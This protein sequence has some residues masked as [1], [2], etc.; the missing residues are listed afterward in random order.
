MEG[1]QIQNFG[2]IKEL[3]IELNS[4]NV[5]IGKQAS[6]KSITVKLIYFFKGIFREIIDGYQS[7]KSKAEIDS[8]IIKKF[9]E[10]FPIDNWPSKTFYIRYFFNDEYIEV[11][12]IDKT[13]IKIEYSELVK[14]QFSNCRRLINSDKE[15]IKNDDEY[16]IYRPSVSITSKYIKRLQK[17]LG[18]TVGLTQIFIPAGRSFFANLQSSIFSFLSNNNAIDPFLIEFGSFYEN[19]KPITTRNYIP[20]S[21]NEIV[22]I[23]DSYL[24]EIL[25]AKYHREKDKDFLVHNDK[26]KINVSFSSSGQ[27][28][29]L[30]LLLILKA[31]SIIG[32]IGDGATIFIEEPEAH[33]FPEAQ[34][35]IVELIASVYKLSNNNLQFFITT[36]SP[37]ILTSCNNLLQAQKV[38]ASLKTNSSINKLNKI[39]PEHT[40]I[41]PLEINSYA[42]NNN[43]AFNIL[44]REFGIIESSYLD[45]VSENIAIDFDGILNLS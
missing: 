42:M 21:K 36:H 25:N 14:K 31:I 20:K 38:R 16:G 41:N 18:Q 40:Q 22:S 5:F 35:K 28:E 26:R 1:V 24:L 11:K 29:T 37:Y 27:Q 43:T 33:L 3:Q 32:F 4:I 12:R 2:G 13:K 7:G 8:V 39:V 10:Y 23:I 15:R 19:I 17:E 34:R 6:G 44:N 9:I 30:P 45:S